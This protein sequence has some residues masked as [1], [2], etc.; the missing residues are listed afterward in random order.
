M[1]VFCI[2]HSDY[3]LVIIC[4]SE[5]ERHCHM[6]ANLHAYLRTTPDI[7][8]YNAKLQDYLGRK[9]KGPNHTQL[10]VSPLVTDQAG[11]MVDQDK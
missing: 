2:L 11:W 8:Q 4:S 6:I 10:G 9:F 3:H 1:Y 7:N 5:E